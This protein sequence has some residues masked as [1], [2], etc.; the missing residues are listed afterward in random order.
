M[1]NDSCKDS[2]CP[3]RL[4]VDVS[5]VRADAMPQHQLLERLDEAL[6]GLRAFEAVNWTAA[7]L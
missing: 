2:S 3:G 5:P 4:I 6:M 7:Y 1:R